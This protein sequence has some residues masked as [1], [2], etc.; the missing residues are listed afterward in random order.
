M[1]KGRN[2]GGESHVRLYAHEMRTPAWVTLDTDARALLVEFRA[3]YCG[4]ENRIHMS[5]REV[6]R[7]LNIG[8]RPA[9]R[10]IKALIDRGWIRLIERGGFNYKI[11]H[12]S[13]YALENEPIEEKDGAKTPKSYMHWKPDDVDFSR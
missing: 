3:L 7:R 9:Q 10:A 4:R 8:Q 11:R 6:Q 13:V 2:K 12:A 1:N 5:V